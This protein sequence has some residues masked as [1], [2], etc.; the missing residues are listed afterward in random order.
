MSAST[1][2]G[3]IFVADEISK[4]QKVGEP[5]KVS[6]SNELVHLLSDQLYQSP[7][8]AIE[9]L[10]VNSYDAEA[11]I[12]RVFVPSPDELDKNYIVVFDDGIGMDRAGLVNLW[13]IGRSNK[14]DVEIEKRRKR[15]QIG[16][17]GIGKLAIYTVANKLTYIT[18]S[19]EGLLSVTI[20]FDVF[21]ASSEG[22]TETLSVPVRKIEKWDEF[23]KSSNIKKALESACIDE[24]EFKKKSWTLAIIED[25]KPKARK[26]TQ[27][28]LQ[29]M[30]STAMP[31]Q[32]DFSL[33]LNC[34]LIV[35]SKEEIDKVVEF[36]VHELPKERLKS[37]RETTGENWK[38]DGKL[39][40]S[41]SFKSGISGNVLVT[42]KTLQ[43]KS[44]DI[45][46]SNGFFIKVRKRLVNES[47]ALFGLTALF[48]GTFNRM[49]ADIQADDLDEGLKASRETIEES[50]LKE[51]FR[52]FL[53]EIYNE[54]NSQYGAYERKKAEEQS[55]KKEGE[56][57]VVAPKLVE[58]PIADAILANIRDES[59]AEPDE[60]WFYLDIEKST[61]LPKL[62]ENLYNSPRNKFQYK[63]T[64][65]GR[66]SR[67]VKFDPSSATFWLN[68]DHELVKQYANEGLASVLLEDFAT[69]EALLEIYLRT[70]SVAP[71]IIGE[72][73]EQR[74][75]LLRSLSKDHLYSSSAISSTLKDAAADEYQLEIALVVAARTLG[76]VAKHIS[77]AGEPD[78]LAR[79]TDYPNGEIKITLEAKSSEK[80]PSLSALDIAGLEEHVQKYQAQGCLLVAPNYPGRG[81]DNAVSNRAKAAKISCWTIDQ[82]AK[83]IEGA[84][85]RQLT[86]KHVLDIVL[87]NFAP[88]DVEDAINKVLSEPTWDK[89]GLYKS[90]LQALRKLESRLQD[91][92]RTVV[93]VATEVS[94]NPSFQDV[95]ASDVDLAIREL[96][97]SSQ[98]GLTMRGEDTIIIQVSFDE[99]DRRVSGLTKT[100]GESRA[101]SNFRNHEND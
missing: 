46:R 28:K 78:G 5:V 71:H 48:H 85:R 52:A 21:T 32:N 11:S 44:D 13:Q 22:S 74:D 91:Q 38:I 81:D 70:N 20:D 67:F 41:D 69:A 93:M 94:S 6:L 27:N 30:L 95:V 80:T 34:T 55:T 47:D 88:R 35:S 36:G 8:K 43:G 87:N 62:V 40:K 76:F 31:L 58:Q 14:R 83:F 17:F 37:L 72:V 86:A 60:S 59:G 56:K 75:S 84:E 10:V 89:R 92:P 101:V 39:V 49:R 25:L 68:T 90:I 66:A 63:Y 51:T 3:E 42:E 18:K 16:K 7:L 19:K 53:R 23:V 98:G 26:I 45:Q 4:L 82:L 24:K 99:L 33:F 29:W 15:K 73:L 61:D 12:C 2:L 54:A 50:K 64:G 97:M 65:Q 79:F 96:A 9:E 77:G 100:S 57:M 1:S